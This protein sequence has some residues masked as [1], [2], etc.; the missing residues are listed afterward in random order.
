MELSNQHLKM[1][2]VARFEGT[3]A[4]LA[5][6]RGHTYDVLRTDLPADTRQGDLFHE[7]EGVYTMD[8]EA[9]QRRREEE[10]HIERELKEGRR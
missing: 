10:D 9:T 6:G 3:Y 7:V 8:G 1:Y 5:D 4:V 2:E